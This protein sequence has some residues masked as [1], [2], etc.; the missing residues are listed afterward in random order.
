MTRYHLLVCV[1][2]RWTV[3]TV[4]AVANQITVPNA[5]RYG[6][7][8]VGGTGRASIEYAARYVHAH[9]PDLSYATK[10]NAQRALARAGRIVH[11]DYGGGDLFVEDLL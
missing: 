1:D 4:D 10:Y 5:D 3:V 9:R 2:N 8:F 11:M 6:R 7:Y